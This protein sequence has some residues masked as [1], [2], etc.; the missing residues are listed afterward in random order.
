MLLEVMREVWSE[1][2]MTKSPWKRWKC[3]GREMMF[4]V[5][6]ADV[7]VRFVEVL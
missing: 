1:S 3:P 5:R 7:L 6:V 4:Q 2:R